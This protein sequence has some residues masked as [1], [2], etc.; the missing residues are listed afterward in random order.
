MGSDAGGETLAQ[1][2]GSV[3]RRPARGTDAIHEQPDNNHNGKAGSN[4]RRSQNDIFSGSSLKGDEGQK[5]NLK[6]NTMMGGSAWELNRAADTDNDNLYDCPR[7]LVSGGPGAWQV[8]RTQLQGNVESTPIEKEI[9]GATTSKT[10]HIKRAPG[11]PTVSMGVWGEKPRNNLVKVKEDGDVRIGRGQV[12]ASNSSHNN[13]NNNKKQYIKGESQ[14]RPLEIHHKNGEIFRT[15]NKEKAE[16]VNLQRNNIVKS[17]V[18]HKTVIQGW[19]SRS[20]QNEL[21]HAPGKTWV[22]SEDITKRHQTTANQEEGRKPGNMDTKVSSGTGSSPAPFYFGMKG[23][24]TMGDEGEGKAIHKTAVGK[25]RGNQTLSQ[26]YRQK[27]RHEEK[28]VTVLTKSE[29]NTI[30]RDILK[31][32]P[33][34]LPPKEVNQEEINKTFQDELARAKLRLKTSEGGRGEAVSRDER[35][36]PPPPP[37]PVLP[38][39]T[40]LK[41]VARPSPVQPFKGKQVNPREELMNAIRQKGGALGL[42]SVRETER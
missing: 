39:T 31:S 25:V 37:P 7:S 12:W 28:L 9:K 20:P 23:P 42:K 13:N 18:N 14:V 41:K 19:T 40:S 26:P 17:S 21:H 34:D 35:D 1:A 8:Q 36:A 33:K 30:R 2:R 4:F 3:I 38:P 16:E 27:P 6:R 15:I 29:P 22:G 11:P 32:V 24:K 5:P 10:E